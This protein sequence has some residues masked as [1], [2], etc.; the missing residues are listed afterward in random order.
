MAI[1]LSVK[2][3]KNLGI[4]L[5]GNL[6]TKKKPSKTKE[7]IGNIKSSNSS[8]SCHADLF[9]VN[10]N[11]RSLTITLI[12]AKTISHN[13]ILR[14]HYA[15]LNGYNKSWYSRIE[16]VVNKNKVE[17]QSW[18]NSVKGELLI[19][20]GLEYSK[21]TRDTDSSSG[22]FKALVDGMVNAG[23]VEDDSP[24]FLL[25]LPPLPVK[26][27]VPKIVLRLKPCPPLESI[28]SKDFVAETFMGK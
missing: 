23:L 4:N 18:V 9:E 20:E 15:A 26:S 25:T 28:F 24:K 22:S 11:E 17:V 13:D 14:Q 12:D 7:K 21:D 6:K 1:R 16:R 19:F 10:A 2:D 3:A 27:E 8:L 5:G